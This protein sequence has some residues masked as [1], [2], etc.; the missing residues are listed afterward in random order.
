MKPFKTNNPKFRL[1]AGTAR[2]C[3]VDETIQ[4]IDSLNEIILASLNR[5]GTQ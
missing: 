1:E 2:R 3:S 4:L 5:I